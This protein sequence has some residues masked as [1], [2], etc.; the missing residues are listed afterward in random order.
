VRLYEQ[1]ILPKARENQETAELAYGKALIPFISWIDALRTE[2]GLQEHYYEAIADY[3]R[4][5][6]ALERAV[7]G[8]LEP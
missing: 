2:A 7:G 1:T 3:F 8:P 5:R 4:R 6:A